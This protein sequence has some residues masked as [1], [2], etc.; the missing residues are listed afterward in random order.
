MDYM[1]LLGSA[2]LAGRSEGAVGLMLTQDADV[3]ASHVLLQT[4]YTMP[5]QPAC[6]ISLQHVQWL[7]SLPVTTVEAIRREC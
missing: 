5:C 4:K 6:V 1:L 7:A 2:G 3:T